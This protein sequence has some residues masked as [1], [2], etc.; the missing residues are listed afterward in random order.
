MVADDIMRFERRGQALFSFGAGEEIDFA[1]DAF[2]YSRGSSRSRAY[3]TSRELC[4]YNLARTMR[5]V[6]GSAHGIRECRAQLP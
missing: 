6:V 1:H 3:R 5:L 2:S 4:I